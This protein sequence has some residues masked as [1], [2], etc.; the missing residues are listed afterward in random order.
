MSKLPKATLNTLIEFVPNN[1]RE[2]NIFDK[3]NKSVLTHYL[4][5][6]KKE[7]FNGMFYLGGQVKMSPNEEITLDKIF[8]VREID[9]KREIEYGGPCN[10]WE[11]ASINH[12]RGLL[13]QMEEIIK[14]YT[15]I[16]N[17]RIEEEIVY[18]LL[19]PNP[20]I[21]NITTNQQINDTTE[22]YI[23]ATTNSNDN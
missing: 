19:P 22:N 11:A 9:K 14:A 17:L 20:P 23:D 15:E 8:E 5:D 21:D 18:N 3:L 16:S 12:H 1:E 7:Y 13:Y 4:D 2:R 10:S 6:S